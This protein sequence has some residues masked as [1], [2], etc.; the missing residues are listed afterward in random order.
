MSLTNTF[1]EDAGALQIK[2]DD[3]Q[4]IA[5]LAK[6]AK[7]LEKEILDLETVFKERKEQYRKLTEESIPEAL[8]GMGMKAFRMDD[9][10][11]I[12]IKAFYSASISEARRAEA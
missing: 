2:D 12:E 1:E 7:H 4:G 10:S 3:I 5:N 9:G 8:S 11:S 6:R